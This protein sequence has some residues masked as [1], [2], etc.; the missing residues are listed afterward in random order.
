METVDVHSLIPTD[1]TFDV[2]LRYSLFIGGIFQIFCIIA[3]VFI[4]EDRADSEVRQVSAVDQHTEIPADTQKSNR[5][6][7]KKLETKKK[8]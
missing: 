1:S 8:R 4:P 5:R 6:K 7:K 2:L 3:A